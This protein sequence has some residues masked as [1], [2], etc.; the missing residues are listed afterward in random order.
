MVLCSAIKGITQSVIADIEKEYSG[1]SSNEM[2]V[3]A[4]T[5]QVRQHPPST[6][7]IACINTTSAGGAV[8][9]ERSSAYRKMLTIYT[10][11]GTPVRI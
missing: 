6:Y 2:T 5:R 9:A 11:N 7:W 8:P 3:E 1:R 4:H 10:A